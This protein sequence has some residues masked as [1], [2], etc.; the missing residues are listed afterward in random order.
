MRRTRGMLPIVALFA[1]ATRR[2]NG[3]GRPLAFI[4][5][6]AGKSCQAQGVENAAVLVFGALFCQGASVRRDH[7]K[8][9]LSVRLLPIQGVTNDVPVGRARQQLADPQERVHRCLERPLAIP[10]EDEFVE[11]GVHVLLA[12]AV[13]SSGRP[14]LEVRENP[15]DTD[16]EDVRRQCVRSTQYHGIVL[17]IR[18]VDVG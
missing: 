3:P 18:D 5:L 17:S 6:G 13:E 4:A 15:V 14:A 8:N 16:E 9:A 1:P 10:S 11:V 7:P 2:Q 12:E